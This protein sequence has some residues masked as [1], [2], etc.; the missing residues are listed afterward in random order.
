MKV[1]FNF[2]TLVWFFAIVFGAY[3]TAQAQSGGFSYQNF[4]SVN[5]LDLTGS[6]ARSGN[7]LRLT[8]NAGGQQGAAF[9]NAEVPVTNFN[10]HVSVSHL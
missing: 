5:G 2:I 7:V 9:Y 10:T 1:K 6:A 8:T 4:S 3:F